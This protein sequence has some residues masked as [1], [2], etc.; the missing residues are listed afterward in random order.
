MRSVLLGFCLVFA[1]VMDA[2]A[3]AVYTFNA[4]G[5]Y[6]NNVFNTV[7]SPYTTAMALTGSFTTQ[8]ALAANL[9]QVDITNQVTTFSFNDGLHTWT[10]GNTVVQAN[11][12][13]LSTDSN[14]NITKFYVNLTDTTN[15]GN[16]FYVYYSGVVEAGIQIQYGQGQV[17][18]QTNPGA[19]S[20]TS[21]TANPTAVS[22]VPALSEYALALLALLFPMTL[23]LNR[24]NDSAPVDAH[25]D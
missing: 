15:N 21:V 13:V 5:N 1:L 3:S 6:Q 12:F 9:S 4:T 10:P 17:N 23:W 2:G 18:S 8:N 24:R 14:G 22:S 20:L 25:R 11:E 7:V 16:T 19:F